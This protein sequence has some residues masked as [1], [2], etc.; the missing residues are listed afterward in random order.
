MD[1]FKL[2]DQITKL[3]IV[4]ALTS[5]DQGSHAAVHCVR[6]WHEHLSPDAAVPGT[7][8]YFKEKT[9]FIDYNMSRKRRRCSSY[10]SVIVM[11]LQSVSNVNL[12]A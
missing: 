12:T 4:I 7:H 2:R 6:L 9:L 1:R 8:P 11:P 10:R 5:S 3:T